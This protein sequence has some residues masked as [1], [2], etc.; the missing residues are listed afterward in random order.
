M[1]LKEV[2]LCCLLASCTTIFGCDNGPENTNDADVGEDAD[3][4]SDGDTEQDPLVL[5]TTSG[6]ARGILDEE[7]GMY[8][9]RGIPFAATTGGENRFRPPQPL[10]P[11]EEVIDAT[12]YGPRCPQNNFFERADESEDCLSINV[13]SPNL[14]PDTPMPV[15]VWVYGGGFDTGAGSDSMYEGT[16]LA[17]NGVI[18]VTFNYRVG[19]FG[20]L[21]HQALSSESG[22]YPSSGNYAVQDTVMAL[23]WVHNNIATFGGDPQNVTIF[24]ESAGA[25]MV[26]LQL[27][28]PENDAFVHRAIFQSG[29][30]G[31]EFPLADAEEHGREFVELAGCT[32]AGDIPACLRALSMDEMLDVEPED[33]S[34]IGNGGPYWAPNTDGH[35]VPEDAMDAYEAGRIIDIDLIM[36]TNRD[37]GDFFVALAGGTRLTEKDY[38]DFTTAFGDRIDGDPLDIEAQ[39]PLGNFKHPKDAISRMITDGMFVCSARRMAR[40]LAAHDHS[41]YLYHYYGVYE[42]AVLL[43]LGAFHSG[44]IPFIF[45]NAHLLGSLEEDDLELADTMQAFWVEFAKTNDP[46]GEGL[47]QWPVYTETEDQHINL[48]LEVTTGTGLL[49]D[50]CDFWDGIYLGTM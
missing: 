50:M 27:V 1:K 14:E 24:G 7:T 49:S 18:V 11:S 26:C 35:V 8:I 5:S 38:H 37:E 16:D 36:G 22:D 6:P 45:H 43:N 15:M 40:N 31:G 47:P 17:A 23:Q 2:L 19:A 12:D 30:C 33:I 20:F 32:S 34:F 28:I 4:D 44:E 39:Y 10:T 29:S 21:A 48:D 9:Y 46:N 25:I 42:T 41:I 13:W 3:G